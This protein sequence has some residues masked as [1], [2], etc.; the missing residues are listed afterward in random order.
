MAKT[1]ERKQGLPNWRDLINSAY[2]AVVIPVLVKIQETLQT[3]SLDF[4]WK[5]LGMLA[6][7][8]ILAH[9]IRKAS[10]K[11]KTITVEKAE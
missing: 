10:E 1:I 4:N 5:D 8:G 3:G 6:L 11:S 9:V 2:Y 7:S